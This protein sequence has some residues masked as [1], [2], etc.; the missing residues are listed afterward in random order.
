VPSKQSGAR[1]V[2]EIAASLA[3]ATIEMAQLP[4]F[5]GLGAATELC[6]MASMSLC[7]LRGRGEG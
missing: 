1:Q 4:S 3:L 2:G 6:A 5:Q 7:N